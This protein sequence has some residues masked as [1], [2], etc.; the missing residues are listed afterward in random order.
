[1]TVIPQT[2]FALY[3]LLG[4]LVRVIGGRGEKKPIK[5][6]VDA[7]TFAAAFFSVF[8]LVNYLT[9]VRR[10]AFNE[11]VPVLVGAAAVISVF[12]FG[13]FLTVKYGRK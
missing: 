3:C 13:M 6:S 12:A 4:A 9:H 11:G 5:T 8:N 10:F 7:I 1:M 2:L